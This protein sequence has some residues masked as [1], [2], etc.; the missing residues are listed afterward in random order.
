MLRLGVRRA[1][2]PGSLSALRAAS[3]F[4]QNRAVQHRAVH[5]SARPLACLDQ[6]D[7]YL[8]Q[9]C[10]S[11]SPSGPSRGGDDS[12][13]PTRRERVRAGVDDLK[14]RVD[15][16]RERGQARVDGLRERG[17]ARVDDLKERGQ[18][19]VDDLRERQGEHAE[20]VAERN[21]SYSEQLKRLL[22]AYGP[23]ALGFHIGVE[24]IVLGGFYYAVSTGMDVAALL[25]IFH[26]ATGLDTSDVLTP[27]AS[28]LLI[29]YG[30]TIT[31]TG[32]PRTILTLVCTPLI[33]RRL[34][35]RPK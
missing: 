13:A 7:R 24:V 30:L 19:R 8:A 12:D 11:T 1:A 16:L 9:R 22:Y 20:W 2:S 26:D 5:V 29:A 15:G 28:S 14:E 31:L 33:A 32:I 17:Q 35:W 3:R 21:L 10:V 6:R 25:S 34:G 27:G 18:A 23:L 4:L